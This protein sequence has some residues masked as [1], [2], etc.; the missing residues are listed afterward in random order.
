MGLVALRQVG[1]SQT[2]ARTR[3]PC[4]GR[5]ILNHWTTREVLIVV[6]ICTSLMNNVVKYLFMC[7]LDICKSSLE[8]Y[9]FISLPVFKLGCLFIIK[10]SLYILDTSPLLDI[11]WFANIFFPF[12]R[13]SFHFFGGVFWS[14]QVFNF[15]EVQFYL[16]FSFVAYAF[17]VISKN[18]QNTSEHTKWT[19]MLVVSY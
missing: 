17:G 2:R 9:L 15:D 1:S 5:R 6:L 7:F 16:F 12:C 19:H 10:S 18:P 13:L 11:I 4:I 14:R 3:V 8:K